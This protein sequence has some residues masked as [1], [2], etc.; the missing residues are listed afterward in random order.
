MQQGVGSGCGVPGYRRRGMIGLAAACWLRGDGDRRMRVVR[1]AHG[2]RCGGV[3]AMG[4]GRVV[5]QH[6]A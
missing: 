1:R 3:G 6:H 5:H 2:M 4:N